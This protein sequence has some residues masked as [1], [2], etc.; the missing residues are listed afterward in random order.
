MTY[1]F[2]SST[3]LALSLTLAGCSTSTFNGKEGTTKGRSQKAAAPAPVSSP[4][5]DE[6]EDEL[7]RAAV[8]KKPAK[9]AVESKPAKPVIEAKPS[10]A[11]DESEPVK[12]PVEIERVEAPV[13]SAPVKAVDASGTIPAALGANGAL[14]LDLT[15]GTR[16]ELTVSMDEAIEFPIVI[17][18]DVDD[19][20]YDIWQSSDFKIADDTGTDGP[21]ITLSNIGTVELV[22][23]SNTPVLKIILHVVP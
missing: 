12:E 6:D 14:V 17:K 19:D 9:A 4:A 13:E 3:I 2:F 7:E 8:E 18:D 15:A 16:F 10:T 11:T 21:V 22:S 1:E 5:A 23:E 20:H